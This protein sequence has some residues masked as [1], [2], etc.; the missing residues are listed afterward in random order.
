MSRIQQ[1]VLRDLTLQVCYLITKEKKEE[2]AK[3]IT[4]SFNRK[5]KEKL[6]SKNTYR[7]EDHKI[8]QLNRR[9]SLYELHQWL[10]K[11]Q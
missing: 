9:E 3:V 5:E 11:F 6:I 10:N 7:I 2:E 1:Q 8:H 4:H